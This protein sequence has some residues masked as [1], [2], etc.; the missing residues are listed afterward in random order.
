MAWGHVEDPA[1]GP[2]QRGGVAIGADHKVGGAKHVRGSRSGAPW[3]SDRGRQPFW[4]RGGRRGLAATGEDSRGVL[5]GLR[6]IAEGVRA[7]RGRGRREDDS[8]GERPSTEREL[9]RRS[10]DLLLQPS[11]DV[12]VVTHELIAVFADFGIHHIAMMEAVTSGARALLQSFDPRAND[13]DLG[14]RLFSATKSKTQWKSYLERF[15]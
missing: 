9:A 11:V 13:L 3:V 5:R 1:L 10:S 12:G 8:T 14:G 4:Q 6:G 2:S 7:V 15:Y